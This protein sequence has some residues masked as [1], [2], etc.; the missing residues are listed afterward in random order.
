MDRNYEREVKIKMPNIQITGVPE[1]K[2][3][4]RGNI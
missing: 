2:K 3:W 4:W 1:S